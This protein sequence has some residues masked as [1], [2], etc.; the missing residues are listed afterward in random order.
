[1]ADNT[2]YT[3]EEFISLKQTID[4]IGNHLPEGLVGMIWDNYKKISGSNE[5]Q[6][7]TCGSSASLWRKAVETIRNYINQNQ[8]SYNG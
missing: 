4:G 3:K 2:L 5:N 7:C 6:P 8:D 1:M